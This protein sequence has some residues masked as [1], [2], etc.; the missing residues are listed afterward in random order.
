M[1]AARLL[2]GIRFGRLVAIKRGETV[3]GRVMWIC[4]CDCGVETVVRGTALTDGNSKSCGCLRRD[5]I[6]EIAKRQGTHGLSRTVE[7]PVWR[8][9]IARCYNSKSRCFRYYGGRGIT[10]CERWRNS[11]EAFLEDMGPRPIANVRMT[12]DR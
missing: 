12:I 4:Q 1:V 8:T 3:N 6:S 2:T 7:Y 11:F 5:T 10:V 9:M